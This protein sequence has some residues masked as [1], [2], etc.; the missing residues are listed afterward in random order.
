VIYTATI[1]LKTGRNKLKSVIASARN[2]GSTDYEAA[3]NTNLVYKLSARKCYIKVH[4]LHMKSAV[5]HVFSAILL[6]HIC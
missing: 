3:M 6:M 5:L 2:G 1:R 4:V